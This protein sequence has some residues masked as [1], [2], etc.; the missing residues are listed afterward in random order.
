M[1]SCVASTCVSE[2]VAPLWL[3][4]GF[5]HSAGRPWAFTARHALG[6][7]SRG[8]GR[9]QHNSGFQNHTAALKSLFLLSWRCIASHMTRMAVTGHEHASS[10]ISGDNIWVLIRFTVYI[11]Q[12]NQDYFAMQT[13]PALTGVY[14]SMTE[15]NFSVSFC[16]NCSYC[17]GCQSEVKR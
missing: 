8:N 17:R 12:Y 6:I 10:A 3:S 7:V 11:Q 4:T 14:S 15:A 9:A 1:R 13:L 16:N 2:L 5:R